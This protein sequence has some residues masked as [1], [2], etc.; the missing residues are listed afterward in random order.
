M[1]QQEQILALNVQAQ[2]LSTVLM[3]IGVA[4]AVLTFLPKIVKVIKEEKK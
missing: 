2:W 1:T 4:G 3:G